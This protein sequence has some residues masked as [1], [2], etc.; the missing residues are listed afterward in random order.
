MITKA[1]ANDRRVGCLAHEQKVFG[2][3]LHLN[4]SIIVGVHDVELAVKSALSL[5]LSIGLA[6]VEL[7]IVIKVCIF[8]RRRE[9]TV[10]PVAEQRVPARFKFAP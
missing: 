6:V 2:P 8:E 5:L 4:L 10:V 1:L 3:F 9:H 7:S